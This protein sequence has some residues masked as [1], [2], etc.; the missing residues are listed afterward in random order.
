MVAANPKAPFSPIRSTFRSLVRRGSLPSWRLK[1]DAANSD[2]QTAGYV[3]VICVAEGSLKG[4]EAREFHLAVS[5]AVRR[6]S[7]VL[8]DMTQITDGNRAVLK[9]L[10]YCL[11]AV[12]GRSELLIGGVCPSLYAVL[13]LVGLPR[14]AK[15]FG[16]REEALRSCF[17]GQ[18]NHL[19]KAA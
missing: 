19:R 1:P 2:Q 8:L 5:R 11:R 16:T 13:E 9:S 4:R 14:W 10:A 7:T 3:S 6:G 12:E 17:E 15:L 18:V